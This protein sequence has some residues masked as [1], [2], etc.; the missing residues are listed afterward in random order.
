[1]RNFTMLSLAAWAPTC[2][3]L[4]ALVGC[5]GGGGG[6]SS[7][8]GGSE[9]GGS[10]PPAPGP[11]FTADYVPLAS[12]D[13]RT[14]LVSKGAASPVQSH[15]RV[16][17]SAQRAGLQAYEVSDE[18]GEV[19][20]LARTDDGLFAVAGPGS[21]DL[22]RAAGLVELMRF[23]LAA[24][25]SAV[26]FDRTLS[27]DVDG[28]R[29]VDSVVFRVTFSVLGFEAVSTPT[30][31]WPQA[32]RVRTELRSTIALASGGSGTVVSTA[33][34]WYVQGIGL[35]RATTTTQAGSDRPE[36]QSQDIVAWGVGN[37]RSE[38]VAPRLLT[39]AP[40]D[41]SSSQ[42]QPQLVRLDFSE[43]LDPLG[44]RTQT[45]VRLLRPDGSVVATTLSLL[46]GGTA[47]ELM[48]TETL[49]EGRYTVQ[50]G[51]G[52]VDLANN[53]LGARD[54][55]FSIDRS[56]PR[57]QSSQ[58]QQDDQEVPLTGTL[59]MTFNEDLV[60]LAGQDL[61]IDVTS[62]GGGLS[63]S[64][65]LPATLVGRTLSAPLTTPL[66]FNRL[67]QMAPRG[68]VA[69][70]AGNGLPIFDIGVRFRTNTGPLASPQTLVDGTEV[71]ATRLGDI[72]GDGRADLVF[73][74]VNKADS[75]PYL[76]MR[77]GLA[78]GGFGAA[79]QLV[80]LGN[81]F[82]CAAG[83]FVLGD[84][85]GDGR[86]DVALACGS[87]LRVYMQTAPGSFV[88]ERP[89]WN[90]GSGFGVG[91]FNGDGRVDLRL[92]GVPAGTDIGAMR[93]WYAITRQ[94]SGGWALV[95]TLAQST[96]FASSFASTFADI[97]NDGRPE[98]VWLRETSD[99][100]REL[101]WAPRLAVGFGETQTFEV[102]S[103]RRATT[104]L[105]V[106]DFDGDGLADVFYAAWLDDVPVVVVQRG[107]GGGRFASPLALRTEYNPYGMRLGDI[108][109]DGRLDLIVSHASR[110]VGVY[111]QTAAGVFE[112]ER[113]FETTGSEFLSGDS[114]LLV[115]VNN[116]GRNDL[117][118]L[119]DVLL[120]RPFDQAW[121]TSWGEP[122]RAKAQGTAPASRRRPLRQL[123]VALSQ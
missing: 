100:R 31:S 103:G 23:G 112:P 47:V 75:V 110:T 51:S 35:V 4:A 17:G 116:D 33:D 21:D 50:L 54:L 14:W 74:G 119:G 26:L 62:V 38:S 36:T 123:G 39:A 81:P 91:D 68:S 92:E 56:N 10:P 94:A 42:V 71:F 46:N 70:R 58:P 109:G 78:G 106:G 44:L 117:V 34:E 65:R 30:A 59:A 118:V 48:P 52:L 37:L 2:L 57:L 101:A 61:Y 104:S 114:L 69:D 88:M 11:R 27:F 40:A 95:A 12:G 25:Q 97:D 8:G 29:R 111:L 108:D 87:F 83:D 20:Y 28:D 82:T 98:P 121:P 13:R 16:G 93:A 63:F 105:A 96:T 19:E 32:A 120:R 3:L 79:R 76:G 115:D 67:L 22:T 107:L 102:F 86:A 73:T 85:D 122:A 72:D 7:A 43:A 99:G 113:V 60:A 49:A 5:G 41:G 66:P 6:G 55:S 15:E 64:L 1:M 80:A 45:G 24:G 53:A 77:P 84:F 89:G 90:G 9:V 18:T